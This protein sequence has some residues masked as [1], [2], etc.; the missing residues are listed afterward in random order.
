MRHHGA[1]KLSRRDH[2]AFQMDM[3]V[4]E[5]GTNHSSPQLDLRLSLIITHS[6]NV[7]I[8]NSNIPI[9]QFCRKNI[10]HPGMLQHQGRLFRP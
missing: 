7:T 2:G 1:L 5:T 9:F 8:L 10:N 4:N 3:A 6:H